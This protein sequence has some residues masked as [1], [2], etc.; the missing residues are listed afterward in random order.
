MAAA[1]VAVAGNSAFA[2]VAGLAATELGA[3]PAEAR[4]WLVGTLAAG[5]AAMPLTGLAGGRFG[6]RRA[7]L[8]GIAGFAICSALASTVTAWPELLLCRLGQGGCTGLLVG[9]QAAVVLDGF[10]V[11]RRAGP[12]AV[13]AVLTVAAGALGPLAGQWGSGH[14]GW[15]VTLAVTAVVAVVAM[16]LVRLVGNTPARRT[17]W[18][19]DAALLAAGLFWAAWLALQ[20]IAG[21]WGTAATTAWVAVVTVA[22]LL[23]AGILLARREPDGGFWRLGWRFGGLLVGLF[24]LGAVVR[25]GVLA[26]LRAPGGLL[27]GGVVLSRP[28]LLAILVVLFTLLWRFAAR[29]WPGAAAVSGAGLILVASL[30]EASSAQ[31]ITPAVAPLATAIGQAVGIELLAVAVAVRAYAAAP[32]NVEGDAAGLVPAAWQLAAISG[33]LLFPLIQ[34]A[35]A[36]R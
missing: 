30:T 24:A 23:A 10:A 20:A 6:R 13:T 29:S 3:S 21:G 22:A 32:P 33:A 12:L 11:N 15:R 2:A 31:G 17:G 1:A 19:P 28:A 8:G 25:P 35:L 36:S 14:Y 27:L 4:A 5:I 7:V 34:Q 18:R 26:V 16:L 9:S